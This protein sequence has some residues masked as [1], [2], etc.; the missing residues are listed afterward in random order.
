MDCNE[1]RRF[2]E[3]YVDG[4]MELTRQLD[5]EAHLAGCTPC[6]KAAETAT[7]FRNAIHMNMPVYKAPPELKAKVQAVLRK[8]LKSETGWISAMRRPLVGATA[9]LVV[10]VLSVAA[11][12]TASH[13]KE[14]ALIAQAVWNHS[15]SLLVDHLLDVAASDQHVVKAWFTEKLG[16]GPQVVDLSEAGYK[17]A[18][19]RLDVLE[20]RQVP[21]IVYRHQDHVIN[22]FVW[23]AANR[24]IDFDVQSHQG[25][26][27]C[28]WNKSGFN[29]LIVSDLSQAET[30]EFEDHL[31]ER[32][33]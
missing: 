16:Y 28:G 2:L 7:K 13:H 29:Y 23:P 6:K 9:V 3:A 8:E 27:M 1:A 15:H 4:E 18:G 14:R 26:S 22:E 31:R 19:G 21:A 25:Y 33:E 12:M 11:W 32:T 20:N 30:E 10:C 5:L 17:L 24:A